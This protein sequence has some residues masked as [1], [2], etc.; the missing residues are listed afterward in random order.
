MPFFCAYIWNISYDIWAIHGIIYGLYHVDG[1]TYGF[2]M[3]YSKNKGVDCI[4]RLFR[5]KMGVDI[6]F[7]SPK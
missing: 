1:M 3:D 4:S 6:F 2:C 5:K 7:M